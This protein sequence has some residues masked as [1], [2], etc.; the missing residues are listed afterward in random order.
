VRPK[1]NVLI[2][3]L[4]PMTLDVMAY[5]LGLRDFAIST[6]GTDKEFRE[7]FAGRAP[8]TVVFIHEGHGDAAIGELCAWAKA[9]DP[10]VRTMV[11]LRRKKCLRN[12]AADSVL[13]QP[14][15]NMAELRETLKTLA[16][17]KRGPKKHVAA[18]PAIELEAVYA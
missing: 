16:M 9:R 14:T 5:V 15:P 17:R 18:A 8:D 13:F 12:V 4:N 6:A 7:K 3:A 10:E 2:F 11:V 1:K